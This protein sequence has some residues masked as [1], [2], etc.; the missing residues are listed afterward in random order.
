MQPS[1]GFYDIFFSTQNIAEKYT[2][3]FTPRHASSN[4]THAEVYSLQHYV[5][6]FDSDFRQVGSFLQVLPLGLS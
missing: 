4:P 2:A 3:L 5:I 1:Q 6:R